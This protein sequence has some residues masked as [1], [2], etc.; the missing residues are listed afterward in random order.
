MSAS[1]RDSRDFC[2]LVH[3]RRTKLRDLVAARVGTVASVGEEIRCLPRGEN[4]DDP[5]VNP[6]AAI[7]QLSHESKRA[8][9]TE[10]RQHRIVEQGVDAP[11]HEWRE[12][13][14]HPGGEQIA[15]SRSD[16]LVRLRKAEVITLVIT[17]ELLELLVAL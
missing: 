12:N 1:L 2:G 16:P 7:D 11:S 14:R 6:K 5:P 4:A 17:S 9:K 3:V 13:A 10:G 15:C 8:W